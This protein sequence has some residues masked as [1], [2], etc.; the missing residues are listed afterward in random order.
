[1]IKDLEL[2]GISGTAEVELCKTMSRMHM[3]N[4]D[5]FLVFFSVHRRCIEGEQQIAVSEQRQLL[6]MA[7]N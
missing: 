3:R 1:M 6:Q 4:K 5:C 7:C 2:H